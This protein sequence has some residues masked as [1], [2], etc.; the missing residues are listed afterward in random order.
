MYLCACVCIC[1]Y[2][3]AY[4]YVCVCDG[5]RDRATKLVQSEILSFITARYYMYREYDI[6]TIYTVQTE[7]FPRS[8]IIL[9]SKTN[10][11]DPRPHG[12]TS[13]LSPA[14]SSSK[15]SPSDRHSCAMTSCPVCSVRPQR[16]GR[17][18]TD[19]RGL[20]TQSAGHE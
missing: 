13:M 20:Q 5:R 15:K 14:S 16:T 18:L 19:R 17:V 11:R 2:V 12:I 8:S 4:M 9:S 6:S 10:C 1:I 3:Y 7:I